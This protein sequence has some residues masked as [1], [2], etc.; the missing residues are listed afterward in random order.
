MIEKY[1]SVFIFIVFSIAFSGTAQTVLQAG[2]LAVLGLASNVGGDLGDCTQDGSG[3]FQ[4]RDRVSFIC[5]KNIEMG[6][7][8]DIT[9]N[10]WERA[11][12][13]Q[14]GNTEGFIRATR[15]GEVIPAG[16]LIT[17]EFP[18]TQTDSEAIA[19]DGDWTFES[20]GTNALNFNDS[21]DQLYF[22]QGGSWNNGTTIGCCN[23][24]QNAEY[25]GGRILFGFNSKSAWTSLL[26]DSQ[27]SALHPAIIPC[28]NMSPSSGV[29]SFTS[30]SGPVDEATQLE[31]I[32][33]IGDPGN[34][35][36]YPTCETYIDPPSS[37][38]IAS[39][40]MA[41]NCRTCRACASFSDTLDLL[42]PITGGP[43]VVQY[44][45]GLDTFELSNVN[46]GAMIPI[47]VTESI[48]YNLVSVINEA[49]CPV[50]SNFDSG[51]DLQLSSTFPV[52][53]CTSISPVPDGAVT[54]SVTDGLS[55]FR[56][57]WTD[58][59]GLIDSITSDGSAPIIIEGLSRKGI[60]D[61][62][63]TDNAGCTATCTFEL[64]GPDCELNLVLNGENLACGDP[65]SG[66]IFA[67][68]TGAQGALTYQWSI[69][70]LSGPVAPALPAG[71]YS[72]TVTDQ[73]GCQ[74][75]SRIDLVEL[76]LPVLDLGRDLTVNRGEI[77]AINPVL[78]FKPASVLWSPLEGISDPNSLF[79]ELSPTSTTQYVVV[80]TN[81]FGCLIRDS[82]LIRV[83][84]EQKLF[85][86]NAFSPNN[87]GVNDI[88]AIYPGPDVQDVR[89]LMVFDR[90]GNLVFEGFSKENPGW[91]GRLPNGQMASSGTY[92]YF[93]AWIDKD[94]K[95]AIEKGA[96]SLLR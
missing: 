13:G 51:A 89:S 54:F 87:D 49:G 26:N 60:Y 40:G 33:R 65:L 21:G 95:E 45:D 1:L 76:E 17:F 79:T 75:S 67:E 7:T 23:G 62:L 11:T 31:W 70:E 19:P 71:E 6:T 35:V 24:E 43:F 82:M 50:Y 44:T 16:T 28:F 72:L 81:Q 2:D 8:I 30:Y 34:W 68:S 92:L 73:A 37:L 96:V 52:L 88:F 47:M 20:L 84:D 27:N 93:L 29:T 86:P 58:D 74:D 69:Q 85:I 61:V 25:I 80:A 32:E 10:G 53:N 22:L 39:S 59:Q 12:V 63:L 36:A 55:P 77:V 41:I 90:W 64:E 4:G 94:G 46:S 57:R 66:E 83:A 18:P 15:T 42:L 48:S 78:N 3:Q 9:D 91:D 56:I 14:W 38:L 5:F